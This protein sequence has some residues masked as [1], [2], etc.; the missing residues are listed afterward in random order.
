MSRIKHKQI[1][2]S[3]SGKFKLYTVLNGLLFPTLRGM[4]HSVDVSGNVIM[5]AEMAMVFTIMLSVLGGVL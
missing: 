1:F 3:N 2:V 5:L 4:S